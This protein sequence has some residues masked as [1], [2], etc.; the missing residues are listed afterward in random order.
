MR[1][2]EKAIKRETIE[3]RPL[4]NSEVATSFGKSSYAVRKT[5]KELGYERK[6]AKKKPFI[7]KMN[8]LK[9]CKWAKKFSKMDSDFWKSVIW[10]DES[11]FC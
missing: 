3:N 4:T 5:L 7:S 8:T 6:V 9:R 10:S 11:K 2:G 1:K